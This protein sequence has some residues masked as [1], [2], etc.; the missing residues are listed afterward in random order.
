M[1]SWFDSSAWVAVVVD[2]DDDDDYKFVMV[3][4]H[5]THLASFTM[6]LNV[7]AR[8]DCGTVQLVLVA[9]GTRIVI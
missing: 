2:V 4:Q 9:Y 8:S 5:E 6:Q 7:G 1:L 3:V